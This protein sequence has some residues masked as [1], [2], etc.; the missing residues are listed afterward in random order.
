MC[1]AVKAGEENALEMLVN[2]FD[3]LDGLEPEPVTEIVPQE[4]PRTRSS[5][6]PALSLE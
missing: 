1:K 5:R 2:L 4:G 3:W 6:P